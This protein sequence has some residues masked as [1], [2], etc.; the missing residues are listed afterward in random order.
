MK[1]LICR[2]TYEPIGRLFVIYA[3]AFHKRDICKQSRPRSGT[4]ERG[5]KLG[6]TLFAFITGI[7]IKHND[8]KEKVAYHWQNVTQKL[9]LGRTPTAR[10]SLFKR[11]IFREKKKSPKIQFY[12]KNASNW[13]GHW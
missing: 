13:W 9:N 10:T 5:V 8:S 3:L 4:A 11:T 12:P 7:S 1:F 6:S 2:I